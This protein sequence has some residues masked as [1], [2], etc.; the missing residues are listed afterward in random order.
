M[1]KDP[2]ETLGVPRTASADEIKRAFRKLAKKHHPDLNP[3]NAAAEARFKAASAA[4]ELLSD[5][6]QRAK[7]D[8]GEINAEGQPTERA[9]YKQYAEGE[10][11]R[12]YR[13]GAAGGGDDEAFSDI[14]SELFRKGG[15]G[16][17][18]EAGFGGGRAFRGQDQHFSIT[19]PFVEAAVGGTRRVSLPEGK[20]L[21]IA[22]PAGLRDGQTI[23]LRG[24]GHSG[25][26][27]GPPGDA[28]IEVSVAPHPFFRREEN[29]IHL[30]LPVT[31]AEAVLGGKV[32]VPTLT[33][34][35][36]LTIPHHSDSGRKLR[37]RGK[38]IPAHGT[39]EAGDLYVT[40]KLV[41]GTPDEGLEQ[42]LRAW[43]ERHPSDPRAHLVEGA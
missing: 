41:V 7:F 1:A 3:G 32:S 6:E 11:G 20:A 22:I 17:G 5:P 15:G 27:G 37:L 34:Q 39:S 28:L 40:L 12:R 9:F 18:G 10:Q 19:I 8:A 21:D 30:D 43:A 35:V 26:N 2:Y 42:A 31:V 36:S 4:N 14:F 23:R 25:W 33:G 38:G 16:A 24:Q 29:D 13:G